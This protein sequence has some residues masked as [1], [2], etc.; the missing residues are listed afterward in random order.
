MYRV[1]RK[2]YR[3]EVILPESNNFISDQNLFNYQAKVLKELAKRESYICVGRACDYILKDYP[4]ILKVFIYAPEEICIER[5]A[6][7]QGISLE[8]ARKYVQTNDRF[9]K[10]YYQYHTSKKWESP[11]NYDLCMNTAEISY[12][13]S[14]QLIQ[15]LVKQKFQI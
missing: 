10:K 7:R 4:R 3:G 5:E 15:G 8:E 6:K 14:V 9:R 11:F 13:E 12:E 2:V 1:Q